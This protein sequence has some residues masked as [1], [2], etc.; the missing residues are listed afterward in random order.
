MATIKRKTEGQIIENYR[1]TLANVENQPQIASALSEYTFDLP[2]IN[3]GRALLQATVLSLD[4]NQQE[5]NETIQA[6]ADFDEK[7]DLMTQKYT[8]HRRKAKVAFRKNEVSLKQL[9][10]TG[11][12]S[13]AYI[14]WIFAMKTFYNGVLSNPA[15]L[16]ALLVFKITEADIT[17]CITEINALETTRAIYLKEIG[18][19]QEATKAKD[20][21][22]AELEEWMSDFYM[23]AKI[24]MEEQPQLLE[25]LGLFVR[26]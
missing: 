20:K 12:Y 4:T 3:I 15:H 13:R 7:V 1:I 2:A 21:A 22:L 14:K 18:E 26:S 5:D 23:V 17:A 19:S 6:R 16:A 24:A 8:A 25:S 10:L 9:G 11:T